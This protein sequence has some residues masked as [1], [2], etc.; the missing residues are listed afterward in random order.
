MCV[1][2]VRQEYL[3][4]NFGRL[5]RLRVLELRENRLTSLP[6]SMSRLTHLQRL[7]LGQNDLSELVGARRRGA[8]HISA[9]PGMADAILT[10]DT[11]DSIY[12]NASNGLCRRGV[13]KPTP[14]M[15]TPFQF[16]WK[17]ALRIA[18]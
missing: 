1:C 13:L 14:Y 18:V 12:G 2:A 6:K 3:P 4:A 16:V 5:S 17:H 9:S 8:A 15:E 10:A 7:D 11:H